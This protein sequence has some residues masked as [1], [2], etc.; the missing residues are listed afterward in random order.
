MVSLD[1]YATVNEDATLSDAVLALER[2]QQA[3]DHTKYR[4]R[5]ILVLD[6]TNRPIGKISQID[7]LKAL[8]P[9]YKE[10][11]GD[12]WASARRTPGTSSRTRSSTSSIHDPR[13]CGRRQ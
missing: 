7:A 12:T 13:R 2:A 1:E 9:K 5:A 10:I 4:H 8:E 6:K 3:F 11:Q